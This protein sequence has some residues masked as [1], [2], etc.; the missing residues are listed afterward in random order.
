MTMAQLLMISLF[1]PLSM[2]FV[3]A[4]WTNAISV[5]T[6][7][8]LLVCPLASFADEGCCFPAARPQR[9]LPM[10]IYE[11]SGLE[12]KSPHS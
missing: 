12:C 2:R 8:P 5:K 4:A 1:N 9:I 11:K 10:Q 3:I 6:C 7:Q